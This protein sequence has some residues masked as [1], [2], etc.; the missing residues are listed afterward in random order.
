MKKVL[1]F[2][3]LGATLSLT[4]CANLLYSDT[5]APVYRGTQGR[6]ASQPVSVGQSVAVGKVVTQQTTTKPA[7]KPV[8]AI[9]Q[10]QA[11]QVVVKDSQNN[12]YDTAK[13]T[14]RPMG[15]KN[16]E[17][18]KEKATEQTTAASVAVDKTTQTMSNSVEK[19]KDTVNAPV[20]VAQQKVTRTTE[21]VSQK[22]KK[23]VE[24]VTQRPSTIVREKT[25]A[26]T[27]TVNTAAS[28][29]TAAIAKAKPATPQSATKSLLQEAR[30]AVNSGQYDKAASALE[31]A[32]RIEPGN[33]KILYDIAQIRYAQGKYVQAQSFASRAANYSSSASLSKKIWTIL[34]KSREKLGNTS[35]AAAAAKKA[36]N[37]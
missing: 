37:F 4:G 2:P 5:A 22:I 15:T 1:F 36:A 20:T 11:P 9:E 14:T 16:A 25:Q 19:V 17:L 34:A 30:S 10:P 8:V 12:P 18:I 26:A 32:H 31:R 23:E 21:Q 13:V 35:G 6:V 27:N 24:P 29:A 33:A 7:E 28:T 3:L